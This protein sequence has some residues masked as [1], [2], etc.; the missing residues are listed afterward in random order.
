MMKQIKTEPIKAETKKNGM[1]I[2]AL[3]IF[4]FSNKKRSRFKKATWVVYIPKLYLDKNAI[5]FC[6]IGDGL[7]I[8]YFFAKTN[9]ITEYKTMLRKRLSYSV[10]VCPVCADKNHVA[11]KVAAKPNKPAIIID[12]TLATN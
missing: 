6:S 7:F 12:L 5:I 3:E 4:N 1:Q 11:P 8:A 2:N 9:I 10:T